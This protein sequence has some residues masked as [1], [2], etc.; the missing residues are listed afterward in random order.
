MKKEFYFLKSV[1]LIF[2]FFLSAC[3]SHIS[4]RS[5]PPAAKVSVI[6][7][8]TQNTKDLGMTPVSMKSSEIVF[9]NSSG[10]YI[11]VVTMPG[12]L[13]KRIFIPRFSGEEMDINFALQSSVNMAQ[14]N[15]VINDL[16]KAQNK[17][18][19]GQFDEA[20][21]LLNP[22]L[23]KHPDLASI[24][25]MRGSVYL[26]KKEAGLALNDF[27]QAHRLDPANVEVTRV[28]NMLSD[29]KA[30]DRLPSSTKPSSEG[31]R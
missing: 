17:A 2:Y 20:I 15:P 3:A 25:E 1:I 7:V 28:Y 11:F 5:T 10:P 31:A 16:F 19:K 29:S 9:E 22:L 26:L 12:F 8:K 14:L 30:N 21:A 24:Y 27:E 13:E 18:N 4:I 23:E 6:D